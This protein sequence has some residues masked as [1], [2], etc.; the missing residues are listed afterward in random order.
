MRA[1]FIETL[2]D[3]ARS[4]DR[5]VLITGDLGFGVV[6][7]FAARFPHQFLNVGVAE[8]NM[9]G[10]AAGMAL[11]G[12]V[13]FTYSIGNFPSLR[14]LEQVRNDVCYHNANVKIISVG[15]GLGYGA[16]GASHHATEDIAVMR[17]LPNM[18]VLSPADDIEAKMATRAVVSHPGPAYLRLGRASEPAVHA[19]NRGFTIGKAIQVA[20][21]DDI[22]LIATG[23][24]VH[25]CMLAARVLAVK[26][27]QSRVLSMHTIK[28]LDE[29]AILSA[30]NETDAIVTAEEHSKI[31]GLGSAVAEVLA[32]RGTHVPFRRVALPSGFISEVGSQQYLR[33]TYSLSAEGVAKAALEAYK[34]AQ[35]SCRF[36]VCLKSCD[37]L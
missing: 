7:P 11:S 8:Q 29:D 32:E 20:N 13:V 37:E 6:E 26:G 31:G 22:A 4:D 34:E 28:P 14:C 35:D 1:A 36:T 9:T 23:S 21:G 2:F 10:I 3:L 12:K 25:V 30:A 16:L 15:A 5:I 19:K 24:M 33:A 27:I 17:A 18:T